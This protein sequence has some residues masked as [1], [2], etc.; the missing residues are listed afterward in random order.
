MGPPS[1]AA[2]KVLGERGVLP[3]HSGGRS[4]SS[5]VFPHFTKGQTAPQRDGRICSFGICSVLCSGGVVGSRFHPSLS[6]FQAAHSGGLAVI[7]D[8]EFILEG[9]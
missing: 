9:S 3:Q 8:R 4:D 6:Y 7:E 2:A 1:Q 5:G